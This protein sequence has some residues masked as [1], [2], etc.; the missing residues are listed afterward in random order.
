MNKPK[1]RQKGECADINSFIST[2]SVS[3][4]PCVDTA[5]GRPTPIHIHC[6]QRQT[7]PGKLSC[8]T[9]A[10]FSHTTPIHHLN[11]TQH[12]R[13]YGGS[14]MIRST[15]GTWYLQKWA[16]KRSSLSRCATSN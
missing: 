11:C 14:C 5:R 3:L 16:R 6:Q 13:I 1:T 10:S 4:L 9:H 12:R 8:N 15:V 7:N 2:V